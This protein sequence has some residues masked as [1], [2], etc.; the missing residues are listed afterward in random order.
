MQQNSFPTN[1]FFGEFYR[2]QPYR[3]KIFIV[4]SLKINK[5]SQMFS[6]NT[7]SNEISQTC[8]FR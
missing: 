6:S 4:Y 7:N 5:S 2:K 1:D 8:R 3:M